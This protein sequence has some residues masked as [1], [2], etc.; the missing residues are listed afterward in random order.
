MI[1]LFFELNQLRIIA[2]IA[3]LGYASYT[4]VTKREV[5]D[6]VWIVFGALSVV[7]LFLEPQF[8]QALTNVGISLIVAPIVLI[9]WRLGMFGGADAFAIIVLALLVPQIT[10]S[11]NTI[12][13]FTILTN[14]VIISIIPFFVNLIRNLIAIGNKNDIFEGF[15]ETRK[16]R[17]IA[18]FIGYKAKNPKYS[19]SIEKK[20]GKQKKLNL[21]M[22]HAEYAEFCEKPN[23]WVTP[24][25]PYMLFITAGFLVQLFYGDIIFS[26][27]G[28]GI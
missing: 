1:E 4:D 14:A 15:S 23:T 27:F 19:F 5:S 7:L 17:I 26:F 20:V 3:M 13:P 8:W 18:L 2:A 16:K 21:V 12:T 28:L 6:Y 25:I 11:E 24:G 22:H 10:M 9:I